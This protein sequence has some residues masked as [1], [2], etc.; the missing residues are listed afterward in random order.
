MKGK[1]LKK[2]KLHLRSIIIFLMLTS[3]SIGTNVYSQSKNVTL[4]VKDVTVRDALKVLEKETGYTFLYKNEV[5]QNKSRISINTK[6]RELESLLK[7]ILFSRGLNYTI[8]DNVIIIT[9]NASPQQN[10]ATRKISGSVKDEDN[11]PLIGVSI[12]L[13]GLNTHVISDIDGNFSISVPV[14]G[15]SILSFSYIGMESKDV[16]AGSSNKLDVILSPS[17]IG[18]GDVVI[19]A[20]YGL[21]QK[22]S[23][24]VGSAYQVNSEQ[25]KNLPPARIDN[26]LEGLVPG[27]SINFNSDS[28]TSTRPRMNTRIRGEGSLTAGSEP[29]WFVDGI[30]IYTG[31]NNNTVSGIDNTISPLSYINPNDIE[32]FTVLKDASAVSI[33]GAD[34]SNGV[35]LITTKKGAVNKTAYNAGVRFGISKINESTKFKILDGNQYMTLA[36]EAY[37]N[38]YAETDPNMT[39]FPFQDSPNNNYSGT[40]TNW[41]DEFYDLGNSQEYSLSLSGGSEKFRNYISTSYF[42]NESTVKGNTQQRFSLRANVDVKLFRQLTFSV[43]TSMSYNVNDIFSPGS[44]YYL[45]LPIVS[46]YD[47]NGDYRLYYD[48]VANKNGVPTY[49]AN[50][51]FNSL[52]VRE[53]NDNR[54]R[55]LATLTSA[56]LRYDIIDG[57]SLTG[58][59]GMDYSSSHEEIYRAMSN[60]SGRNTLDGNKEVGYSFRNTANN[61]Y[62]NGVIRLN[63]NRKFG[64][65]TIGSLLGGEAQSKE[66]RSVR[67]S[68][69]TFAND[70]I[71][72]INGAVNTTSS[73][74]ETINHSTSFL[75]QLSYSYDER[76]YLTANGRRDGNSDFGEDVQ[77]GQFGSVGASWNI[78]NEPSF[79]IDAINIMKL[80]A[81]YGTAGNSRLGNVQARGIYNYGYSYSNAAGAIMQSIR[82]RKLSWETAY[83][84]NIG[85][86]VKFLNRFD[87]EVEVYDKITDNLISDS[88]ISLTTGKTSI[89]ANIAKM[90]NQG[91][92]ISIESVNIKT[93]DFMWT[94][95]L[96]ASHNKNKIL[97]LYVARLG[98]N[99]KVWRV[100]EDVNTWSLVRW[101]G[102]NPRNGEPLWYDANGNL[103]NVYDSNN[104]V[105]Y[106]RSTPDL[107]GGFMNSFSY[108]NFSLGIIMT[109]GI[110]GYA[111]STFSRNIVSDGLYIM[112][113]NQSVNQLDRW[114]KPGDI[115]ISPKPLWGLSTNSVRNSTRFLFNKTHMRLKNIVLGYNLPKDY[116]RKAGF[117]D[118]SV[119]LIAD[120]IAIWT[121]YGKSGR[122]TYAQSISGYPTEMS[123][124]LGL[125]LTF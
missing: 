18:L 24:L 90:K 68:G 86:R 91:I 37:L 40:N 28:D 50:R 76:Y 49:T 103:T 97:E 70:Y 47:D 108:K 66:N 65:H 8:D 3:I 71:K 104:A 88:G 82:N 77:W 20:G 124:T 115:A 48:Y 12:K 27:L 51:F 122:N 56:S 111:F 98:A 22:R 41:Y 52:A 4:N 106:K 67:A 7:E 94:S 23:D 87:V 80:K 25:I 92:E 123:F 13:K 114:Q 101:A 85:L 93:K 117:Q 61:M 74:S 54:Q 69:N 53:E 44:D 15:Q 6:D 11:S 16:I 5:L 102:V 43:N 35:I 1:S 84:T 72:E 59:F 118:G 39:Y 81:S 42:R 73:S 78:H 63:Y 45:F 109:Y 34:G 121:L 55:T 75:G 107:E 125:N 26:M 46:P 33:Y 89:D 2:I 58:Q 110:G 96:N 17:S 9:N 31:N 14:E 36:K 120:N 10:S 38:R 64:K 19:E 32:S 116:L 119:S 57:L 112:S 113:Q 83:L 100:G 62:W 60:W 21:A 79:D 30:R 99:N 105:P 95:S 29:I